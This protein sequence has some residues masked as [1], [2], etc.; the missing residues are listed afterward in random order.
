MHRAIFVVC[1]VLGFVANPAVSALSASL[2]G[3]TGGSPSS[4]PV[5]I[6]SDSPP[7]ERM[8]QAPQAGFVDGFLVRVFWKN[9]EP[10]DGRF[11]WDLFDRPIEMAQ[12]HGKKITLAVVCGPMSPDWLYSEGAKSFSFTFNNPYLRFSG[13][14][15]RIPLPW[16]PVYLAKWE[17]LIKALG[18]RYNQNATVVLVHMTT[19]TK[20]GFEMQIPVAMRSV[21]GFSDSKIID[22]TEKVMN[23]FSLAFPDKY[24]DIDLHPLFDQGLHDNSVAREIARYGHERIGRRF[25]IFASWWSNRNSLVFAAQYD[26]TVSSAQSSF[27]TVQMA[28]SETR[29]P[30]R[31]DL[32]SSADLAMRNGIRY[33]EIWPADLLNDRFE[34]LFER[35]HERLHKGTGQ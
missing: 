13:R 31:L 24:L 22:S 17:A 19:S 26:L 32:A 28:G 6:F 8:L 15:F 12:R 23:A 34:G 4:A 3:A 21:S 16:D 1:L 10:E 35:I 2:G 30:F 18:A 9:L 27:A 7:T 5:G 20:N 33:L 29:T 14:T 11:N 25:G